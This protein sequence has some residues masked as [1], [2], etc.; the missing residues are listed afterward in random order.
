MAVADLIDAF[1][2]VSEPRFTC[3][4][5]LQWYETKD[6]TQFQRLRFSGTGENG[7]VFK[8]E[9]DLLRPDTDLNEAARAVARRL[10]NQPAP[11]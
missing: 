4:K 7:N 10:L 8:I 11:I 6:Q 2:S 3:V 9:S 1:N 5:A